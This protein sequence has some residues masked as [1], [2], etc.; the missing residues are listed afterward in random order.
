MTAAPGTTPASLEFPE[1]PAPS[2][3]HR[4]APETVERDCRLSESLIWAVQ[5]RYF[6]SLG[7]SAWSE[8]HVP[9]YV[10]SNPFFAD[11]Y[12][13]AAAGFYR[14]ACP[15]PDALATAGGRLRV[16]EFGAGHGRFSYLFLTRLLELLAGSPLRGLPLRYQMTD[17]SPATLAAWTQ[18]PA[19]RRLVAEGVLEFARFDAEDP[20][21]PRPLVPEPAGGPAA[22][23]PAGPLVLIANYFFDSVPADCFTVSGGRLAEKLITIQ[24]PPSLDL[25]RSDSFGRLELSFRSRPVEAGGY[26][27]PDLDR[28]LVDYTT[29]LGEGDFLLPVAALRCLRFFAER[30]GGPVLVLAADKGHPHTRDLGRATEP[31]FVQH[32]GCFS[33]MVNFDALARFTEAR[34]GRSFRLARAAHHLQFAGYLLGP[35]EGRWEV[36]EQAL[37]AGFEEFGPDDFYSLKAVLDAQAGVVSVPQALAYLRLSHWDPDC[38]LSCYPRLLELAGEVSDRERAELAS[39]I[40]RVWSRYYPAGEATDLPYCLGFLAARLGL[41]G[42]AIGLLEASIAH[43]GVHPATCLQL[44]TCHNGLHRPGEAL[45][46]VER[47]LDLDPSSE[48]ARTM[49]LMLRA[50]LDGIAPAGLS[51][52]G[53]QRVRP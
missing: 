53:E 45:I 10:T 44:G 34:G 37:L 11:A 21:W 19:L 2:P 36:T 16:I 27:E 15:E 35:G 32:G 42:A 50:E 48:Q 8:G 18:H 40:D 26:G 31:G 14:D 38:F 25:T 1:A 13:R 41:F 30:A 39:M 9:F 52:E 51:A 22:E 29:E 43:F 6:Q 46:W 12:A 4:P 7:V 24:A 23:P 3:W 5:R 49:R 28:L 20:D 47:A 17:F 33:L